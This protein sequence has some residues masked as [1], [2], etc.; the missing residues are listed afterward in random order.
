MGL[1][2]SLGNLFSLGTSQD[3]TKY[4]KGRE[5][6][7]KTGIELKKIETELDNIS[8]RKENGEDIDLKKEY[9]AIIEK[10][11]SLKKNAKNDDH[12]IEN[13][14]EVLIA[15]TKRRIQRIDQPHGITLEEAR[16]RSAEVYGKKE[17][18]NE[19]G[20][21]SIGSGN[22]GGGSGGTKG[23]PVNQGGNFANFSFGTGSFSENQ[24]GR[25]TN[26]SSRSVNR[27]KK[28]DTL[29]KA[30]KDIG[31][32]KTQLDKLSEKEAQ[33][34]LNKTYRKMTLKY[35]P[36]KNV[37][38]GDDRKKEINERIRN[39][40]LAK[41]EITNSYLEK[42]K[43]QGG[44]LENDSKRTQEKTKLEKDLEYKKNI[45]EKA[46]E[47]LEEEKKGG[48]SVKNAKE[49]VAK[50]EKEV[51]K[52]E[53]EEAAKKAEEEKQKK[54]KQKAKNPMDDTSLFS[55]STT[56]PAKQPE[57]K[58]VADPIKHNT[59][60]AVNM[61]ASTKLTSAPT[62]TPKSKAAKLQI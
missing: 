6:D 42:R 23:I 13:Q 33:E 22:S 52:I 62:P 36:D 57:S 1:L 26:D 55:G 27:S 20:S 58:K 34:L 44:K 28:E 39:I 12:N 24:K 31:L 41:T 2:K 21:G 30:F 11:N 60:S 4:M 45:L 15:R 14:K 48:K 56:I 25:G 47:K 43:E 7:E 10:L 61:Q 3:N 37:G 9:Q 5:N 49:A 35:H 53:K 46:K 54:A 50:A 16:A 32:T 59:S 38:V 19:D 18:S 51:A 29:E 8:K 40:N 17:D